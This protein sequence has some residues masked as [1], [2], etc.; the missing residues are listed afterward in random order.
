MTGPAEIAL[1]PRR[2]ANCMVLS[3]P[4]RVDH[5]NAEGLRAALAPHLAECATGRDALVLD[6]AQL[7]YISSAGLRILMLA[8][9]QVKSQGGTMAI[10]AMQPVVAE[11]FEISRFNLVFQTHDTVRQALAALSP[12]A[13]AAFGD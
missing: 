7:E 5:Q 6:C 1:Q 4:G 10:A 3:P 12:A 13:L 2:F 9:K 11:I 8:A